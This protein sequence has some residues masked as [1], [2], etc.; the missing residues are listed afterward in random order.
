ML[1]DVNGD[2]YFSIMLTPEQMAKLP[3]N[4]TPNFSTIWQS[5]E[6]DQDGNLLPWPTAVVTAYDL[7]GNPS[8]TMLQ[9]VGA[10]Q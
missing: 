1:T 4:D 5:N 7:N 2:T 9:A 8:G 10:F 3:K 6:R